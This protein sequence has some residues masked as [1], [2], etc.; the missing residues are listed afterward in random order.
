MEI[1][2]IG[3]IFF[4][5]TVVLSILLALTWRK[6]SNRTVSDIWREFEFKTSLNDPPSSK[7]AFEWLWENKRLHI[8][9]YISENFE[10]IGLEYYQFKH[11]FHSER[12]KDA[13]RRSKGYIHKNEPIKTAE[14]VFRDWEQVAMDEAKLANYYQEKLNQFVESIKKENN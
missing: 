4:I 13:S 5:T 6:S 11:K 9:N 8:T 10:D 3:L 12:A 7:E 2:I 1:T 14:F